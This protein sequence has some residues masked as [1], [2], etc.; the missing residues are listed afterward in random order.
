[1]T[2]LTDSL[3]RFTVRQSDDIV[4]TDLELTCDECGIVVCDVEAN[5]NL[6]VLAECADEH[7]CDGPVVGFPQTE[8]D[9]K[10]CVHNNLVW[11][12][13]ECGLCEEVG[14]YVWL[15]VADANA[16]KRALD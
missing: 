1:M 2:L 6:K 12:G 11:L 14:K 8:A 5:D 16:L 4:K 10:L 13:H 9:A 15:E 7:T 3:H